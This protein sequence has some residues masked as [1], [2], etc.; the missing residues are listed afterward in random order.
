M[1]KEHESKVRAYLES[2][3]SEKGAECGGNMRVRG[4]QA[5]NGKGNNIRREQSENIT[6]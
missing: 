4:K 1:G 3:P 6:E 2:E 5:E